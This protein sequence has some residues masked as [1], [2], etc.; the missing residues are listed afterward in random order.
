MYGG[1]ILITRIYN[2]VFITDKLEK[3]KNLYIKDGK[4]FVLTDEMLPFDEEIDAKGLY[5]SPGFIDIHTHGA[6][7]YDFTDGTVDDILNAAKAHAMHGTTT[8]FPT[9]ASMSYDDTIK[10]VKNVKEAMKHN[11]S[12]KP[13][14]AGSHLEG[15]YFS[16]GQRGAQNP[17]YIKAPVKEEYTSFVEAGEGTVKRMSYAPELEGSKELCEYLNNN[18]VISAFAHTDAVYEEIKPLIDMGCKIA[19]HLYSGM[20][21]VTRK[22]LGR[23]LGA[24][25]TAFLEDE[26]LAEVIADGIHLPIPLLKLIFKIKGADKICLVTDS[27]R[28]AAQREGKSV[29]GPKND[30]VDCIVK[31]GIAYLPD[32]TAYAG[33]VATADRIVRVMHKDAEI[34]ICDVIKMMCETP[35]K[36]LNLK[37]RG[38]IAEGY[39][40]DL[41]FFDDDIKIQKV[42]IEGKELN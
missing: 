23:K 39:F 30:G 26:I 7:G 12:G 4:F 38:K 1:V 28:G 15:P 36:A 20:N 37:N 22:G 13:Y 34:P 11:T 41:V 42:I 10:F 9:S 29:L 16:Q 17:L 5:V 2:G 19:T 14:I 8:V 27:M 3:D 33:S 31:D 32:M 18:D 35:A 21:T 6:G 25:E 24:V 40:A